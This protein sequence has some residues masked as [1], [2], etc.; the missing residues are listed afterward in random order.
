MPP[1]VATCA[2]SVIGVDPNTP[3]DPAAWVGLVANR[4]ANLSPT[5]TRDSISSPSAFTPSVIIA[6]PLAG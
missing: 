1:G 3:T 4:P 5:S 6:S 2:D